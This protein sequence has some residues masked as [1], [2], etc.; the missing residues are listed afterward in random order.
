MGRREDNGNKARE[1]DVPDCTLGN[2]SVGVGLYDERK[3]F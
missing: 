2:G 3:M 1:R